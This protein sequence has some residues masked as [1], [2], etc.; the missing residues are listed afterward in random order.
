MLKL[1]MSISDGDFFSRSPMSGFCGWEKSTTP[2]SHDLSD[3]D[4][5][6]DAS[7]EQP[8]A[9]VKL[10]LWTIAHDGASLTAL[11]G[12][13][14]DRLNTLLATTAAATGGIIAGMAGAIAGGII[15]IGGGIMPN[16]PMGGIIM[17]P[18]GAIIMGFIH[19]MGGGMAPGGG[20]MGLG[21]MYNG[22]VGKPHTI[23]GDGNAGSCPHEWPI[24]SFPLSAA[25][26]AVAL[27]GAEGRGVEAARCGRFC[28]IGWWMR[29]SSPDMRL[30]A[31]PDPAPLLL[32]L[33]HAAKAG[34][35]WTADMA[36]LEGAAGRS[37]ISM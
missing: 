22:V 10:M 1:I 33:L 5:S 37:P 23:P 20:I 6:G 27:T 14:S 28:S 21:E 29:R 9:I 34:L 13:L 8:F 15:P 7:A 26:A 24:A 3:D 36:P 17:P 2:D 31:R 32:P 19:G 35:T 18:G 30:L 16:I 25:G 4:L 11:S 12:E